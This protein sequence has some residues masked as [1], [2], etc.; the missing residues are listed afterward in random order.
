MADPIQSLFDFRVPISKKDAKAAGLKRFF[1]GTPCKQGHLSERHVINGQCIECSNERSVAWHK[2]NPERTLAAHKRN[3]DKYRDEYK[4]RAD[5]YR[6]NNRKKVLAYRKAAQRRWAKANPEE[7][8]ATEH[9]HRVKCEEKRAIQAGCV[10]P[11]ECDV[12]GPEARGPICFDHSHQTGEFRGWLC[13]GCNF[14][15]GQVNDSPEILEA[16]AR[17][18]RQ[19]L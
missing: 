11:T 2:A 19:K 12:C 7:A 8:R 16:L 3:R 5:E 17:Y 15:L 13:S 1:D 10:R 6:A 4:A 14:A 18:L 9:R